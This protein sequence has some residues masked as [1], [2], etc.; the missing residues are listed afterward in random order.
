M[1]VRVPGLLIRGPTL[2]LRSSLDDILRA[3]R[4]ALPASV[5]R[6]T[7]PLW[8]RPARTCGGDLHIGRAGGDHERGADV[9]QLVRCVGNGPVLVRGGEAVC[10]PEV[11]PSG[12]VAEE[13][14]PVPVDQS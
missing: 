2:I 1:V 6:T 4:L 3:L 5:I 13:T 14:S 8:R 11:L 9:A 10:Q 12:G 7:T